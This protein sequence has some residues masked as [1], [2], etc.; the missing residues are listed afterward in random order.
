MDM[1]G[2]EVGVLDSFGKREKRVLP[3]W[4]D[5]DMR[6][7]LMT[8]MGLVTTVL[9]APATTDDQKL[10]II[11]LPEKLSAGSLFLKTESM[12]ESSG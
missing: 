12:H 4:P 1:V 11:V 7:V 8:Q 3:W 2:R 10:T 5:C 6:R 9:Q